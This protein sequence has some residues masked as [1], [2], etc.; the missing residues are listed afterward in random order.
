MITTD[1]FLRKT[2]SENDF[3]DEYAVEVCVE[4][5]RVRVFETA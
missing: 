1:N 2:A 4:A 3:A 5:L